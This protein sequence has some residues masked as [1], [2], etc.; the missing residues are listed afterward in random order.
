[1]AGRPAHFNYLRVIGRLDGIHKTHKLSITFLVHVDVD[2]DAC[3]IVV[4]PRAPVPQDLMV[5][6]L[7]EAIGCLRYDTTE[8]KKRFTISMATSPW[9]DVPGCRSAP[10]PPAGL[11]LTPEKGGLYEPHHETH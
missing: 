2:G 1:M 10:F 5:G 7:V 8:G 3:K 6:D 4:W 11:D 9:S